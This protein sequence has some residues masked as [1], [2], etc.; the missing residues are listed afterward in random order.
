MQAILFAPALLQR[1]LSLRSVIAATVFLLCVS[2]SGSD[3]SLYPLEQGLSWEYQIAAGYMPGSSGGQR[4]NVTNLPQ[5]ELSGR[6]VT[7]QKLD[8]VGQS[9]FDFIVSD[10]TG[11]YSYASQSAGAV[12][13]EILAIPSYLLKYPLEDGALWEGAT[14]T[15]M[16][17]YKVRIATTTTVESIDEAVTVPAGTF[18][19]CVKTKTMGERSE[20][21]GAFMGTAKVTLEEHVWFCPSIGLVKHVRK[22]GSNNLMMG[23]GQLSIELVSFKR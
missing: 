11:I 16:L 12:E 23:S 22:E 21:L 1:K 5:R 3:R 4:M 15:V 7:P 13:P 19:H 9:N 20:N 8:F 2:C 14:E 17:D 10:Q 18:E 6:K